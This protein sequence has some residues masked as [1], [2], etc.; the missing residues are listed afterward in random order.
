MSHEQKEAK[1]YYQM[2]SDD[3]LADRF[4]ELAT[5]STVS[6]RVSSNSSVSEAHLVTGNTILLVIVARIHVL[7]NILWYV[8][9]FQALHN[10]IVYYLKS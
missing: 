7:R 5:H 4:L 6:S 9:N 1:H 3:A 10:V 8:C 2:Y